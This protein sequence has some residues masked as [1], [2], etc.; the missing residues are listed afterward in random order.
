MGPQ[1]KTGTPMRRLR[2]RAWEKMLRREYVRDRG[3]SDR[4]WD[5]KTND[6]RA[7]LRN[8]LRRGYEVCL[9]ELRRMMNTRLWGVTKQ[10]RV[11][12]KWEPTPLVRARRGLTTR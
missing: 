2:K 6:G 9:A 11:Q 12:T 8:G 3:R 1:R 10:E 7:A 4:C 5:A